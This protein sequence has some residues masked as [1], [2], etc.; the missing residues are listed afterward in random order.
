MLSMLAGRTRNIQDA[1]FNKTITATC[2]TDCQDTYAYVYPNEPYL[3]YFCGLFF[4]APFTGTDSKAGVFV[5]ELSHFNII[6]GTDDV[7]Y[8]Q[9]NA[10]ELARSYPATAITNADNYEYFAENTPP[11]EMPAESSDDGGGGGGGCFIRSLMD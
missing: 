5:H 4:S 1:L 2:P 8:G 11:L 3:I 7:V 10:R 9:A 6:A